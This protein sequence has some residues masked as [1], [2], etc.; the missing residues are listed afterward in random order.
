M[1][2]KAISGSG[3]GTHTYHDKEAARAWQKRVL[4]FISL[5]QNRQES[6]SAV[7]SSLSRGATRAVLFCHIA[8]FPPH[9]RALAP[10]QFQTAH[11]GNIICRFAWHNSYFSKKG[12]YKQRRAIN[13]S[14]AHFVFWKRAAEKFAHW[15]EGLFRLRRLEANDNGSRAVLAFSQRSLTTLSRQRINIGVYGVQAICRYEIRKTPGNK[16][17]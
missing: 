1:N 12:H 16:A 17:E 11:S 9:S 6:I 13:F 10:S 5:Q 14:R 2:S 15:G 3:G 8:N 4:F 7:G